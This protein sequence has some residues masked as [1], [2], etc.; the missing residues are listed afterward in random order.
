MPRPRRRAH[1]TLAYLRVS[2]EEQATSRAGLDAQR[3][4]ITAQTERRG[5]T[6]VEYVEDAGWSGKNLD[7]PGL[8]HCLVELA[9]HRADVLVTSK[10]DR[11]TRSPV[12]YYALMAQSR[13]EGWALVTLDL[14]LDTSTPAGEF[15]AGTMAG[16]SQFERRL[17]GQR[18]SDAMKAK[19]DAD[20]TWRTGRPR[21]MDP[22]IRGRILDEHR[23]GRGFS[24]IA[25]GLNADAVPTPRGGA[26]W[27]P[28]SIQKVVQG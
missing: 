4:A 26:R 23:S 6:D 14:D 2:T 7:R 25:A 9:E 17:I 18:T 10:Q 20:P 11:L 13:R 22:A 3:A 24:T 19:K 12:D 1:R 5:W 8:Q 28:S 15:L 16:A 27:Y 21:V